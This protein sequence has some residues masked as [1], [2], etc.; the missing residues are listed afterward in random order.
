MCA[1]ATKLLYKTFISL[2]LKFV[3]TSS[4]NHVFCKVF[5][6]RFPQGAL[7]SLSYLSLFIFALFLAT[8]WSQMLVLLLLNA[9]L[10]KFSLC[11]SA[12]PGISSTQKYVFSQ[13]GCL[14]FCSI[15]W[16]V[17]PR[18]TTNITVCAVLL[19]I[20]PP[21]WDCVLADTANLMTVYMYG[22]M[23]SPPERWLSLLDCLV[24]AS[25]ALSPFAPEQ[26]KRI[27]AS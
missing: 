26:V 1:T 16:F 19:L 13:S 15:I 17:V 9:L 12:S 21:V 11:N 22:C 6:A 27:Y 4:W 5:L 23:W 3:F 14:G 24:V 20:G 10:H 7:S 18:L 2:I 8:A 25:P